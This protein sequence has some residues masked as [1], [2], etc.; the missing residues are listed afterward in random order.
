[1]REART[2]A[3]LNL[4]LRLVGRRAD[5]Y[6]LLQSLVA[7]ADAGDVL[8]V[9]ESARLSLA[10]NG[11]F[12]PGLEAGEDN[13]VL[14]AAHALQAASGTRKGAHLE[15]EKHLP[16]ASGIGGGSGDA[17]AALRL[18]AEWWQVPLEESALSRLALSLGADIPV[19]L[20]GRAG[21]MEGVGEI[22]RPLAKFPPLFAVLI[23]PRLPLATA[24][25]FRH[26][27]GQGVA[28][29][30]PITLPESF[31][32]ADGLLDYLEHQPND[33]QASAMAMMPAIAAR[34]DALGSLSSVRLAR[35]SGS[36]ATC[37]GLCLTEDEA[38]AAADA[39]RGHYPHDWIVAC[40]LC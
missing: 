24:D 23:N 6:H 38:R 33:L 13:L 2:R 40:T 26:R 17:A 32:Q 25:V 1:M 29:C 30:E 7:F 11:P 34:L 9:K 12:A 28:C 4:T 15:L 21:W 18:L 20:Q 16:V 22:Y 31:E 8:R 19:C 37:Y 3:K 27:A 5:G 35:L 14:R 36:G 39:L 10:I